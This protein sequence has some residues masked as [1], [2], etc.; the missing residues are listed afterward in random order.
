MEDV[1]IMKIEWGESSSDHFAGTSEKKSET[2]RQCPHCGR[3]FSRG[4]IPHMEN[5]EL[6][7]NPMMHFD[8]ERG[9]LLKKRCA[10]CDSWLVWYDPLDDQPGQHDES[11][12]H[13][14]GHPYE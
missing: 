3:W 12:S 4:Y 2:D 9:M 6:E 1:I 5:C 13:F 14:S 7:E 8:T 11:C 10:E